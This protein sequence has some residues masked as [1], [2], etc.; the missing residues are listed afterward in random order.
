MSVVHV[1]DTVTEWARA[2]ICDHILLKQPPADTDAAMDSGYEYTRVHPAA[3]PL[4]MPTAEKNP[5]NFHAPYPALCVGFTQ[6]Q[7]EA[8][9]G[10]GMVDLQLLLSA[11]NPG[12]HGRDVLLPA[13]DNTFQVWSGEKAEAFFQRSAEGWRDVWN[14]ADT[15]LRAVESVTNIGGYAIDRTAPIK[16]GPLTEQ[17][18]VPDLYP[19]WFAWISFRVTYPLRR[20]IQSINSFL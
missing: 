10:Q 5:P 9:A 6:G 12:V 17:E 13:G 3:F 7:D 11:W 2:N 1:I 19:F 4:Y 15:A 20:N 18:S 14:F 8:A 16:F